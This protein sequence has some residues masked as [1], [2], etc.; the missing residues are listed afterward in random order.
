MRYLYLLVT[1]PVMLWWM[2][3]GL[4]S[5]LLCWLFLLSLRLSVGNLYANFMGQSLHRAA[6]E[7][8]RA[9]EDT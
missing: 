9:A 7:Y 1:F 6:V 8:R 4:V 3:W 5:G 2:F